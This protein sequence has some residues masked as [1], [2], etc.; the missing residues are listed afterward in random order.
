MED[1]ENTICTDQKVYKSPFYSWYELDNLTIHT[2]NN[3]NRNYNY[4]Y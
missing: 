3:K 1:T 2:Y 4:N